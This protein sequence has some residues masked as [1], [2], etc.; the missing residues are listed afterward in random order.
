MWITPPDRE[1]RRWR[2]EIWPDARVRVYALSGRWVS[3]A[4][5]REPR[6]IGAWML[7]RNIDPDHLQ[8]G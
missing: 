6:D 7:N 5:Q 3:S 8:P 1:G 4:P 2:L